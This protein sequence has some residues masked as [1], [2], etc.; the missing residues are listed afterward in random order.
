MKNRRTPSIWKLRRLA[1]YINDGPKCEIDGLWVPARP[2]GL[3]SLQQ[4]VRCAWAVFTGK[5][6]AVVWPEDD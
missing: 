3:W 1:E 5:A 2:E 6:D 4:R